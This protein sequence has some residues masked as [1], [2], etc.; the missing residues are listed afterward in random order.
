[1]LKRKIS[2]LFLLFF[3]VLTAKAELI[4]IGILDKQAITS[5]VFYPQVGK[6]IVYTESGKLLDIDN[7]EI[8]EISYRNQKVFLKTLEKDYGYFNKIRIIGVSNKCF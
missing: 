4:N 1:M 7:T 2:I 3:V 8:I 6:Y 5:F